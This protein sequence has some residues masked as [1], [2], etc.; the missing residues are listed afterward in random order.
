M[1]YQRSLLKLVFRDGEFGGLEVVCRRMKVADAMAAT[2]LA[3]VDQADPAQQVAAL[4]KVTEILAS[5]IVSW[6]LED[7]DGE[8]VPTD[9]E[10]LREQD[11][12]MV[13][14]LVTKWMEVAVGVSPPLSKPSN[15]G[16]PSLEELI[17][18]EELSPSLLS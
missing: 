18:M 14:A 17:P 8:P 13:N 2:A 7:E 5:H 11:F 1:G 4:E 16:E 9:L 6:N 12:Q 15:G 3:K 10:H